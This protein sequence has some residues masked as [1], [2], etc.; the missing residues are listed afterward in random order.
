ML[1][2]FFSFKYVCLNFYLQNSL[3]VLCVLAVDNGLFCL[4]FINPFSPRKKISC[5]NFKKTCTN[6][7]LFC[8]QV[9]KSPFIFLQGKK[10]Q[11][12][13][14]RLICLHV[15]NHFSICGL[16]LQST[17]YFTTVCKVGFGLQ[18]ATVRHGRWLQRRKIKLIGRYSPPLLGL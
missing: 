17:I 4:T 5:K 6:Q 9:N 13:S 10:H 3:F 18:S 11:G 15:L 2:V 8:K 12:S 16:E 14:I 7:S 1:D